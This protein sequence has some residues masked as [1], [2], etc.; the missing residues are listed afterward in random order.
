MDAVI[1]KRIVEKVGN[2]LG[3][4]MRNIENPPQGMGSTVIFAQDVTGKEYAIKIGEDV[5][6]DIQALELVAKNGNKIPIPRTLG[7]FDFSEE[8]VLV[9][10]RI[11]FPLLEDIPENELGKFIQPML[12]QLRN[13]HFIKSPFAGL[14]ADKNKFRNW[15]D[16]LLF[17]YS[18]RHAWFDWDEV[19]LRE[20]VE[21]DLIWESMEKIK[22]K[23]EQ[24]D[25]PGKEYSLLHTDFNQ[26]N[27]FVD[28]IRYRITGIIDWSEATFGDPLY[29]FARVHMFIIHFNLGDNVME[30]YFDIL[31]LTT[32]EKHR[33]ELYLESQMLD[34]IAW[35]SQEKND[36]NNS[37]LRMHQ[38]FL[39][40]VR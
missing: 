14:V 18:G 39:R 11:K 40:K 38:D 15:K 24:T 9:M 34:Y 17:K 27:L 4:K 30:Q 28:P 22:S 13:L 12:E 35:Y 21:G 31:G 19:A 3:I 8:R 23:I 5:D 16:F 10:E 37:R 1:Q 6:N 26:R 33:E 2:E 29:D 20:E 25:L 7:Y 32:E 36:F